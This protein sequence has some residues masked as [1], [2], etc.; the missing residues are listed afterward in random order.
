MKREPEKKTQQVVESGVMPSEVLLRRYENA[1][2]ST[3]HRFGN[4]TRKEARCLLNDV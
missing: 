2:S 1:Q 3:E 4:E